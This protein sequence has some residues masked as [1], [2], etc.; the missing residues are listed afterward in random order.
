[1]L[2]EVRACFITVSN[3]LSAAAL[4]REAEKRA[5]EERAKAEKARQDE[6]AALKARLLE[7]EG[8]VPPPPRKKL[9]VTCPLPPGSS[10]EP[11]AMPVAVAIP[12]P[13]AAP[14]VVPVPSA[15]ATL[16]APAPM[17]PPPARKPVGR[18]GFCR[19]VAVCAAPDSK[20]AK[21]ESTGRGGRGGRGGA[22]GRGRGGAAGRGGRGGKAPPVPPFTGG[23]GV[24]EVSRDDAMCEETQILHDDS[25]E[26]EGA[27]AVASAYEGD[28]Q[29]PDWD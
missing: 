1:M 13:V 11:T 6:I 10:A 23:S 2:R 26:D 28:T 12:A 16:A 24:A 21:P 19:R 18:G 25:T 4:K 29:P 3:T 14:S 17:P 8:G 27:G 20:R 22:A 7:L 5:E 15:A 9:V